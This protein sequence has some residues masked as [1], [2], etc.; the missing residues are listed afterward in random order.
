MTE[1]KFTQ[2]S[3]FCTYLTRDNERKSIEKDWRQGIWLLIHYEKVMMYLCLLDIMLGPRQTKMSI[4][5]PHW[6]FYFIF[7]P[8]GKLTCGLVPK[9]RH[10]TMCNRSRLQ[11]AALQTIHLQ[12][13]VW[14]M[15]PIVFD[16]R[17]VSSETLGAL[18]SFISCVWVTV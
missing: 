12:I 17:T 13:Q 15:E 2:F 7:Y 4:D 1:S 10:Q 5:Q 8:E 16:L 6:H 3:S 11:M 18:P 14:M 9:K